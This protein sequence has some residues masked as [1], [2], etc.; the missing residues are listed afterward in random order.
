MTPFASGEPARKGE[1][2]LAQAGEGRGLLTVSCIIAPGDRHHLGTFFKHTHALGVS[3]Q[4]LVAFDSTGQARS[5]A[6]CLLLFGSPR[7]LS[8]S[9]RELEEVRQRYIAGEVKG[10]AIAVIRLVPFDPQGSWLGALKVIPPGSKALSQ[11]VNQDEGWSQVSRGVRGLVVRVMR[12]GGNRPT[13]P[14]PV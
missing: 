7:L 14:F 9:F 13:A 4:D 5:N 11:Y 8:D 3:M 12:P 1:G 2:P 6:P 10:D